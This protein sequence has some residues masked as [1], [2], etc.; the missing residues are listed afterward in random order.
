MNFAN[1]KPRE[2]IEKTKLHWRW[3]R[4]EISNFEYIMRL[5]VLAG[6][7]SNDLTQYPVVP[8]VLK[9]FTSRMFPQCIN[10]FATSKTQFIVQQ[11]KKQRK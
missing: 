7:T 1:R 8:H 11:K 4:R 2:I 6:R 9:D 10:L 5:N 3:C